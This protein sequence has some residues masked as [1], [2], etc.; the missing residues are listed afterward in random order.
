MNILNNLLLYKNGRFISSHKAL[1]A[2]AFETASNP[3]YDGY[4]RKAN[5]MVYTSFDNK[6]SGTGIFRLCML[7]QL[8]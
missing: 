1:R 3:Q 2:E 6:S 8:Q 5:S 7:M 4:H